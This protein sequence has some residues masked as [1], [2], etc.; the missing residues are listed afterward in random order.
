MKVNS[1]IQNTELIEMILDL[2]E[3]DGEISPEK[4]QNISISDVL[5][6][7]RS[8]HQYYLT[9]T[10]PEIEQ[11]IVH[12]LIRYGQENQLL[13]SLAYFFNEYKKHLVEHIVMEERELFPY[14]QN[15]VD[16]SANPALFEKKISNK[17]FRIKSFIDSHSPIEDEL[18]EVNQII[19][20]YSEGQTKQEVPL[21]YQIF[22]NQ[23][24]IFEL[25]LR[26][27]AIIEDSILVPMAL[28]LE[29]KVF[30]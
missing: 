11:S 21:P 5:A 23:V 7:L 25:E 1:D 2:Y 27:H 8:T 4:L 17:E 29:Q 28:E 9:K 10:L 26:K 14:I 19:H 13:T 12:F 18:Q 20:K 22:L 24:E 15:L 30:A 16:V 3:N 6:Y